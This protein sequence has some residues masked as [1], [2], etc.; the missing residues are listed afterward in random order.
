MAGVVLVVAGAGV[1]GWVGWQMWGTTWVSERRHDQIAAELEQEWRG[2][3]QLVQVEEGPAT[4]M[5]EI[6]A[7]G[8]DYRVPLLEGTAE[9]VLAAGFG[10]VVDTQAPGQVGNFVLSG[11]RTT[12]GEPLADMPDLEPGDE[13]VVT[14][15]DTIYTY[16]L[17]TG[18]DDLAVALDETWVLD[19]A[20]VNPD[21]GVQ[22][23]GPRSHHGC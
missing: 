1:L 5:V 11:H 16:V 8:E 20:P 18:G 21:G 19:P 10:H 2:G 22:P 23:P 12:H 13:V 15:A 7:F 17:D 6:P 14:T 9:D 3:D 4:A